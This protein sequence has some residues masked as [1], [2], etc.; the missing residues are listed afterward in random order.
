MKVAANV[1]ACGRY[2]VEGSNIVLGK[3]L[4]GIFN[5]DSYYAVGTMPLT[6]SGEV[7]PLTKQ[8]IDECLKLGLEYNPLN[9]DYKSY[10]HHEPDDNSTQLLLSKQV[11][12]RDN[13]AYILNFTPSTTYHTF[14]SLPITNVP[15][16]TVSNF[17]DSTLDL[18]RD[19]DLSHITFDYKTLYSRPNNT[20]LVKSKSIPLVHYQL[21]YEIGTIT[22]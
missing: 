10:K 8:D 1:V 22:N 6:A 14:V 18:L 5:M 3:G 17:H 2:K 13:K 15:Y 11:I 20:L 12:I 21:V 9:V 16:G 7:Q 4:A 19:C